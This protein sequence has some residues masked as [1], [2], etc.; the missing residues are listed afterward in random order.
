MVE[1]PP[2][3]IEELFDQ[4]V[5]L[6]PARLATFLD[7]QC[8]GDVHLRAAVEEL[9]QLDRSAHAAESLLR[10]PLAGSRPKAFAPPAPRFPAIDRYRVVRVLGE[11]GMGAVYEAEQDSPRRSVALKVV[12]ADL[13]SP[14]LLKRFT[15]EAQILA[16]LHHPGIAQVYEAGLADD[17]Q[18]FFAMELIRGLPLD[19]YANRQGLDLAA[20]VGLVARVADAVQ[21]AHDRGVIHRDLKP[22]N[23]LVDEAGQPKVLDFGVA[24][25]TDADLLTAAGLTRTGQLLGTPNYMS[26][27]QVTGDPA[28]IDRRTDVYA[29]GVILFELLA[30]RLPYQL[31]NRP[32][33]EA[34]RLILEQDPPRLG[35]L[36]PELR[37]EVETIVAKALEKDP[38]RRYTSAADL[39]ADLQR[40][41][42]HQP[43][44]ARPP[45]AM[46]H[47]RK[48]ARRNKGLVGGAVAALAALVLGLIGTILF[49]VGEAHQRGLAEQNAQAARDEKR[50]AQFQAYRARLS[51]AVA[52]LQNNDVTDAARHLD[53]APEALR[54][55][56]WRHLRSRLDD[57]IAVIP[58]PPSG[59]VLL[60]GPRGLRV[61][62]VADQSVRLLDEQGHAEPTVAFPHQQGKIWVAAKAPD[63]LLAVDRVSGTIRRLRD[64]TGTVRFDVQVPADRTI[65]VVE[66]SPDR[67]RLAIVWS[68]PGHFSV[69]VYDLSG[70]EQARMTEPHRA[71]VWS[72]VFS[73]DGTRLASASDDG[74]ARLW[75]AATGRPMSGPLR[76]PGNSQVL[77]AAFRRDG[78]R[79]VTTAGNG[80][81][82]QW[83]ARTGA[84][85]EP[86]YER[87]VGEVWT[88]VYS[89]DG[90]WVA[91]AGTD[92]TIRLWRATGRE[93][94]LA[95]HGHTGRVTQLA[96][97]ADGR[98]LGS[99]SDDG[100]ARIWEAAPGASLPVLRGHSNFVYPVAYSPDGQWIASGSWDGTVRLWDARTGDACAVLR[101][102]GV[103]RSLAFSPDS[104]WLVSG[105]DADDR[106]RLWDVATGTRRKEIQGP[107]ARILSVAVSPDGTLIAAVDWDGN[108]SVR[109]VA[110]GQQVARIQ[111]GGRGQTKGLAFSPDGRRLASTTPEFHVY[112]WDVRTHQ[113]TKPLTGHTGE[114]FCVTFSRDGRRLA[115]ASLDR[116]V[117]VW[118]VEKGDCQAILR[119]H[120]DDVFTAAFDPSGTL[121]ATAGRDRSVWLWDLARGEEVARLPGHTS[122]IWSLAFSP[123]G[124]TL[125]SG[126]GDSTVRLWDTAPLRTRYQA[127]HEAEA[128]RPAAERLVESLWRQNPSPAGVVDALRA[129]SGLSEPLRQAALRAV[130]RMAQPPETAPGNPPR[131][132]GDG[133]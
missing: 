57:S 133:R 114:V 103:V 99:V 37:D 28:A 7:E 4:A 49:A 10:S 84:A 58:T 43:I 8:A 34:A 33:A 54:G 85:V 119:G 126:S 105:G 61:L 124:A 128:L 106:L 112:L 51:A 13:A 67:K 23:I 60:P 111:L 31:E 125:A 12:R 98:R 100:T 93:D 72:L 15:H 87:H 118:D 52:A 39:A 131:R 17:G 91:S 30:H 81:V 29:L 38:A 94:A 9:L 75:D 25:A 71:E 22:T 45:S 89:P 130:L 95:L 83:D 32:L 101:H 41:L 24:H 97:S 127:R 65:D 35:S 90:E 70:R 115:S 113:P 19:E 123:D 53:A 56:E 96:F 129:D 63:G 20:R 66:F 2:R 68:G 132:P 120:T 1:P 44:L 46:Y 14:A 59:T 18:P 86:P 74:T 88:A 76:H 11:G 21:H 42:N 62:I 48:F 92:R 26:P 109:D 6:D 78:A 69:R 108:L 36:D 64:P 110:T 27:E 47:L 121:L 77:S 104:S 55:W 5:D 82:C 40:W 80:T 79:I 3:R 117:R 73:P 50:E 102:P 116:T 16:R 122:Y 107:G